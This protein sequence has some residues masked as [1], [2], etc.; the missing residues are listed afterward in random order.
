MDVRNSLRIIVAGLTLLT[1]VMN[2]AY[3]AQAATA[4][5]INVSVDVALDRFVKDVKGAKEFLN[6]A[7]GVLVIPNVV[8]AG[9]IIGG[10]YGEG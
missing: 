4:K 2:P 3:T 9:L 7:K 10:E 6:A 5:E 8:Q 1:L